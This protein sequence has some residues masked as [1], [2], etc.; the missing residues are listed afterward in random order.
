MVLGPCWGAVITG[1]SLQRINSAQ[2]GN[3]PINWRATI[4]TAGQ[5]S[6][7]GAEV[8]ISITAS[9][10][11]S[12]V[13]LQ[14]TSTPGRSYT[15]QMKDNLQSTTWQILETVTATATSTTVQDAPP[16]LTQRYYRVIQN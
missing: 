13:Q 5:S 8:R 3:D 1:Q 4:P 15:V 12:P 2:F 16:T 9:G 14:F 10:A 6:G 11:T 7:G